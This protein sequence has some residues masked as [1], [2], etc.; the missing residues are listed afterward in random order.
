[1]IWR[2]SDLTKGIEV[3]LMWIFVNLL[4]LL[5]CVVKEHSA[6]STWGNDMTVAIR[7]GN[8]YSM[9]QLLADASVHD[10]EREICMGLTPLQYAA[11]T[12]S[13]TISTLLEAGSNPNLAHIATRT[14]PLM[15]AARSGDAKG[16]SILL[17]AL[18][19]DAVNEIDEHGST[20]LLLCSLSCNAKIAEI[21]LNAGAQIFKQDFN[22]NTAL[23]VGAFYCSETL[24]REFAELLLNFNHEE[25]S[26]YI[27][28][29]SKYGRTA[30][31]LAAK[32]GNEGYFSALLDAG[33]DENM[34]SSYDDKTIE[35]FK[36]EY[37]MSKEL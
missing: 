25:T 6:A 27:D 23:H 21:L 33:A 30:L 15:F 13:A 28:V 4:L 22:G 34:V 14:T 11:K 18:E 37:Q 20:A 26:T 12:N 35:D 19:E 2:G 29:M 32:N 17:N 1:M 24:G 3:I 31:M 5:T 8:V 36:L 10:L 9:Q 7:D 16:V